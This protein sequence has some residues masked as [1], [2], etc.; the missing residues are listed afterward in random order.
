MRTFS[1]D[2]ALLHSAF[3]AVVEAGEG[4]AALDL[5]ERA[6]ALGQRSRGGDEAAAD[7]LASLVAELDLSETEM[8]IRLL[9]RWF[10]LLNLAEDNE[11]VRRLRQREERLAPEPRRGGLRDAVQRLAAEGTTAAELAEML[12]HAEVRLVMTAHPTEARR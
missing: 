9:T 8:L 2:E 11:R 6:V 7:R 4:T 12:A 3:A 10:Q 5:H 1:D